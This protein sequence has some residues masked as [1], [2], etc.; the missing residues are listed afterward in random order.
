[1][2]NPGRKYTL[3]IGVFSLT[4]ILLWFGKVDSGGFVTVTIGI[5]GAY[6]GANVFQ[7]KYEKPNDK[8]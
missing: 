8:E 2:N 6:L 7:K 3:V 1:M 5:V 4:A